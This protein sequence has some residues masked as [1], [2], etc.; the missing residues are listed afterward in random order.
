MA[1]DPY[2]AAGR[3][4]VAVID[5]AISQAQADLQAHVVNNDLESAGESE[6]QIANLRA[7]RQNLLNLHAE[8]QRSQTPPP[9]PSEA[10]LQAMP[11]QN[12]SHNQWF[13]YLQKTT[14]HGVDVDAYRRGVAE[15]AARRARGE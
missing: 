14:K 8:Y 12:M 4:R 6:Q 5:A 3:H 2:I 15:V 11:V 1:D 10:E 9:E 13:N 7:D